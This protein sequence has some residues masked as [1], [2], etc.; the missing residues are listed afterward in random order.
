MAPNTT[1]GKVLQ[2]VRTPQGLA[3]EPVEDLATGL[4]SEFFADEPDVV[5]RRNAINAV[6]QRLGLGGPGRR[7]AARLLAEAWQLLENNSLICRDPDQAQGDWWF[8]T[9]AGR[10]LLDSQDQELSLYALLNPPA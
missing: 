5:S 7:A 3:A 8:L 9:R 4:L 6:C 10:R 1:L 2:G